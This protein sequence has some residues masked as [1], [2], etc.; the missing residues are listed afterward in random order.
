M[1]KE[2][3]GKALICVS[4]KLNCQIIKK[5][6]IHDWSSEKQMQRK[7]EWVKIRQ[8]ERRGVSSLSNEGL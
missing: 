4:L 6:G 1:G 7:G 3:K 2:K 5:E 8:R